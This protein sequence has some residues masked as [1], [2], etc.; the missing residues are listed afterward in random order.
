M[1]RRDIETRPSGQDRDPVLAEPL[2]GFVSNRL[3]VLSLETPCG[4]GP[5]EESRARERGEDIRKQKHHNS[6]E[7]LRDLSRQERKR[8]GVLG[9]V[10]IDDD[11][12]LRV[13]KQIRASPN[14]YIICTPATTNEPACLILKG[15]RD[16]HIAQTPTNLETKYKFSNQRGSKLRMFNVPTHRKLHT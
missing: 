8:E 4:D 13:I 10:T 2:Q 1:I 9:G 16:A 6:L 5:R 11:R 12:D 3:D 15:L 7:T 14:T